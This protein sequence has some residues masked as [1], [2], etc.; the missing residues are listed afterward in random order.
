MK[1]AM[2]RYAAAQLSPMAVKKSDCAA[3]AIMA[4]IE[5]TKIKTMNIV[6]A[7]RKQKKKR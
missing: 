3:R 5:V 4:Y 2:M 6:V 1:E 7:I